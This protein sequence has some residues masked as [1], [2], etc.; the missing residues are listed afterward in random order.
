MQKVTFDLANL[1]WQLELLI[2]L[3]PSITDSI[4]ENEWDFPVATDPNGQTVEILEH[5]IKTDFDGFRAFLRAVE[6]GFKKNGS[7]PGA[8]G[9]IFKS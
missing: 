5:F 6:S 7:T 4:F 1:L 3:D 9:E 8:V 2:K